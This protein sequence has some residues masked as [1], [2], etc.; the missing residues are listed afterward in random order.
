[1][2]LTF[3][4]GENYWPINSICASGHV[5]KVNIGDGS[6]VIVSRIGKPNTRKFTYRAGIYE[7]KCWLV[8]EPVDVAFEIKDG[9]P[10]WLQEYD[11]PNRTSIVG[12][13][14][15]DETAIKVAKLVHR[16]GQFYTIVR[17]KRDG[18]AYLELY[19]H[20]AREEE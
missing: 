3:Y 4:D 20:Q 8:S 2:N 18:L 13:Y 1:M 19:C 6:D 9:E 16:E 15:D 7:D 14:L 17:Y 12:T 11:K 5:L 10:S